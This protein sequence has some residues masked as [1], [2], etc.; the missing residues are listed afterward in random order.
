MLKNLDIFELA[1]NKLMTDGS[2]DY[3]IETLDTK[4]EIFDAC[5]DRILDY[6]ATIRK[7]IN[8]H[9]SAAKLF[10]EGESTNKSKHFKKCRSYYKRRYNYDG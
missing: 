4:E 9:P 1:Y 7:W 8:Q 2:V 6:A 5:F 10:L 3:F